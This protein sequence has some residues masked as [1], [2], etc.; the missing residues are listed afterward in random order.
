[1]LKVGVIDSGVKALQHPGPLVARGFRLNQRRVIEGEACPD[2]LGHGSAVCQVISS[3]VPDCALFVAQVFSDQLIC[4]PLQIAAALDWLR[5]EQVTIVNMSLGLAEDRPVLKA[6]CQRAMS[7]GML[8]VAS[9]PARG[10]A[11]FPGAYPAV[12][13]ATGDARCQPGEISFLN[14]QQADFGAHVR[15]LEEKIAG[16][17]IGCARVTAALAHI[18]NQSP[19]EKPTDWLARLV[20]SACYVGPE[21][22]YGH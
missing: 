5:Q 19:K 20:N 14:S 2:K 22:R 7:A 9:A 10:R 8:L 3:Q 17:S 13:R 16:A 6:A 18:A 1:M 12:L 11:V 4:T 15:C 21:R